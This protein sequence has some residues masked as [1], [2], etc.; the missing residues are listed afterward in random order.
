MLEA[1]RRQHF[2]TIEGILALHFVMEGP[3]ACIQR[4]E[5]GAILFVH[6]VLS[7]KETPVDVISYVIK[8]QLLH[9]AKPNVVPAPRAGKRPR[10]SYAVEE[11][12]WSELSQA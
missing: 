4:T 7:H 5:S 12:L 9:L 6:R 1:I 3:L 10:V 2:P 11:A 8:R